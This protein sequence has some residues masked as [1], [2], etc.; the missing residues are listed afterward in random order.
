MHGL[1]FLVAHVLDILEKIRFDG[2][3]SFIFSPREG[4]PAAKMEDLTPHEEKQAR[5]ERLLELQNKITYE[6][7]S[8]CVGKTYKVL[9]EGTSKENDG[10]YSACIQCGKVLRALYEYDLGT[11][12]SF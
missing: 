5:F 4:T 3:F 6:K 8:A 10:C 12:G 1:E 11:N 7:T 9:V 2:I